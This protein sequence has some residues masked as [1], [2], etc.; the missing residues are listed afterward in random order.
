MEIRLNRVDDAEALSRY[1]AENF[2][3]LYRWEPKRDSDFHSISSWRERLREREKAYESGVSAH[4]ISYDPG[5]GSVVATCE[6]TGIARGPFQAAFL[7]YSVAKS[8]EGKGR[9]KQLCG[10]VI[11]FAFETLELNRL[12]ANYMPA[13]LRSEGLLK[14]LGFVREGFARKYL[15]INGRWEDHVLTS[16]M[17]PKNR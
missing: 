16:L 8:H 5:S 3:H 14:S 17:N 1:H 6:L 9:M 10:H 2:E 4:F 15:Y 7:G 13:N 11:T 12:M